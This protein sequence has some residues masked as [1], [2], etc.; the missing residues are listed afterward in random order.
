M[1]ANAVY[2]IA[3]LLHQKISSTQAIGI[4]QNL[5]RL[6]ALFALLPKVP[7]ALVAIVVNA[8]SQAWG[9]RRMK[10]LAGGIANMA[11]SKDPEVK[12]A[13]LAV[14]KRMLPGVVYFSVSG[15]IT[16][17]LISIFGNTTKVAQ[18]G[19]LGRLA[20]VFTFLSLFASTVLI[21]RFARL[22]PVRRLILKRYIQVMSILAM[23]GIGIVGM[24]A[25]F[26]SEVL[27][28]LGR[29]Y[30]GLTHEVV[31]LVLGS[32][33]TLLAQITFGMGSARGYVIHPGL[34]ITLEVLWQLTLVFLVDLHTVRGI[35]WMSLGM[36]MFQFVMQ[37]TYV[38]RRIRLLPTGI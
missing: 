13:I 5:G 28:I 31:L 19:A 8:C 34:S 9:T 4:Y 3:P 11:V 38:V 27:W 26:P 21:P 33:F 18:V 1:L 20:Q 14:V 24:V 36:A 17:F 22:Q 15:Q 32:V 10:R 25:A 2:G 16:V 30:S 7:S 37:A 23:V 35:L 29:Q 6:G 12:S